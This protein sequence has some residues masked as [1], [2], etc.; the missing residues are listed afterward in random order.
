M[1][2]P[3]QKLGENKALIKLMQDHYDAGG[4]VAAICAAPGLVLSQLKGIKGATVTCYD[5][6]EHKLTGGRSCFES[7]AAHYQRTHYYRTQSAMHF[8]CI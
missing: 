6:F 4:T 2:C 5:G 3:G 7:R 1:A 8:L